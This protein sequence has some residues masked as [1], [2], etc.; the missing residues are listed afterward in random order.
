MP[1]TRDIERVK[2]TAI[3]FWMVVFVL[4]VEFMIVESFNPYWNFAKVEIGALAGVFI[5]WK[6]GVAFEGRK[7]VGMY[8]LIA[9]FSIFLGAGMLFVI[10][11]PIHSIL[12][13]ATTEE[14]SMVASVTQCIVLMLVQYPLFR[15]IVGSNRHLT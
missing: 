3:L 12:W 7:S 10:G 9:T 13:Q 5:L 14:A 2:E 4:G 6:R 11:R 1:E 8:S 15:S